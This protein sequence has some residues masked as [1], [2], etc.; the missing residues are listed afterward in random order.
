MPDKIKVDGIV[1]EKMP[2][3]IF[4]I[5]GVAQ[6]LKATRPTAVFATNFGIEPVAA[7]IGVIVDNFGEIEVI[8]K[9]D[10]GRLCRAVKEGE[11]GLS[12]GKYPLPDGSTTRH[13][14][15]E[16][17]NVGL[18]EEVL[19]KAFT[20][21][22]V[23]KQCSKA[24]NG[25]VPFLEV[26]RSNGVPVKIDNLSKLSKK[27]RA[28]YESYFIGTLDGGPSPAAVAAAA[29]AVAVESRI[30]ENI[31]PSELQAY[32]N[33]TGLVT[34]GADL[35]TSGQKRDLIII[36]AEIKA[37]STGLKDGAEEIRRGIPAGV[38]YVFGNS[39]VDFSSFDSVV[40]SLSN[41]DIYPYVNAD[42]PNDQAV[43]AS[44][45]QVLA[46]NIISDAN[47][48]TKITQNIRD[49]KNVVESKFGEGSYDNLINALV[50]GHTLADGTK[51][52]PMTMFR[53]SLNEYGSDRGGFL[54]E[55][56]DRDV[57]VE[58]AQAVLGSM[59]TLVRHTR[60]DRN[61]LG[62][63]FDAPVTIGD[64]PFGGEVILQIPAAK[65]AEGKLAGSPEVRTLNT[66]KIAQEGKVNPDASH[67]IVGGG[68]VKDICK[69][70]TNEL[71]A[72][73]LA[74]RDE[75]SKCQA[76][77]SVG[78]VGEQAVVKGPQIG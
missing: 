18:P 54:A 6:F 76:V 14:L 78:T 27:D 74:K 12:I 26:C 67:S 66:D 57:R 38:H 28:D 58:T 10:I 1:L 45:A 43:A 75:Q 24:F 8:A 56:Q 30:A 37:V 70:S 29:P 64:K 34:K 2:L 5:G 13:S 59:E 60:T 53:A 71:H 32:L 61:A 31:T 7:N 73:V 51:V 23:L 52:E 65:I 22:M 48:E 16:I 62:F 69:I 3:S 4:S 40:K 25:M 44:A 17:F 21:P 49:L 9:R 35:A 50:D 11:L 33:E 46:K 15:T 39:S 63:A 47:P 68:S 19:A 20:D 72:F 41:P 36:N 77:N 55:Y 42:V